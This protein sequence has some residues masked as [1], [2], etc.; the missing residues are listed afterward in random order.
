MQQMTDYP[1][2]TLKDIYK[3]FFQ[4]AFGPGHLMSDAEDAEKRMEAYL[5]SECE[6]AERDVDLHIAFN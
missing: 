4:D 3:N 2:S 1:E 5:R 6:Q